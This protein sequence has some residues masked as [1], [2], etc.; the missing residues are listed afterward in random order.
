MSENIFSCRV[1]PSNLKENTLINSQRRGGWTWYFTHTGIVHIKTSSCVK[2][3][4][5]T[6]KTFQKN[7]QVR[8]VVYS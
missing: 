3:I 1:Q 7:I 8:F 4:Q 5:F 6:I 2:E